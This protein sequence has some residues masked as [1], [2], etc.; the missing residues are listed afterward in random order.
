MP[1]SLRASL[2]APTKF[3]LNSNGLALFGHSYSIPYVSVVT[4]PPWLPF[5]VSDAVFFDWR[6][7]LAL[8]KC[9]LDVLRQRGAIKVQMSYFTRQISTNAIITSTTAPRVLRR[10]I[11]GRS[12]CP[13][14]PE[15]TLEACDLYPVYILYF[16]LTTLALAI[17]TNV[18]WTTSLAMPWRSRRQCAG[19][20]CLARHH[21]GLGRAWRSFLSSALNSRAINQSFG[22]S[23]AMLTS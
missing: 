1:L 11:D 19:V 14:R 17:I 9:A 2:Y 20:F 15:A 8:M 13:R 4:E 5:L 3:S 7:T 16:M 23:E 22:A 12:S 21:P 6:A 10:W 18:T